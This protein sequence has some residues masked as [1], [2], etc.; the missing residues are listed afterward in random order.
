MKLKIMKSKAIIT[1][2]SVLSA[3]AVEAQDIEMNV[4]GTAP[5]GASKIFLWYSGPGYPIDSVAVQEGRFAMKKMLPGNRFL[6]VGDGH[7]VAQF[8]N[9]GTP[10]TVDL[11]EGKIEGSAQNMKFR[12]CQRKI[13]GY[14]QSLSALYQ[15]YRQLSSDGGEETAQRKKAI[16]Q[17][18]DSLQQ[19]QMDELVAI[20]EGN[21]DTQIPAFFI[22]MAAHLFPYEQ[23]KS[24]LAPGTAYH[25]NKL[26]DGAKAQLKS[27]ELKQPGKLFTDLAMNDVDGKEHKLSEWCGKG[28]YVLIDFWA[29]W[30]GPCRAEMPNVVAC[31]NKY[32]DKGFNVVGISFDQKAAD[33][34]AA[35]ATL[36]MDWPNISDLKGWKSEGAVVYGINGIPSN[37]LLDKEGRIMASDLRG[38][39][40]AGKLKEI[41]GF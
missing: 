2:L 34:K 17:Q 28:Q 16:E 36:G 8:I 27:M 40:L 14:N 41:F 7:H 32:K 15:E 5:E 31:F 23:L 20:V 21:A 30:C 18:F 29:S 37:L 6:M 22:S 1:I 26:L 38:E 19:C 39:Q 9:D 13:D 35:I 25:D 4:S 3:V 33:W 10:V 11:S 24:M 12:E